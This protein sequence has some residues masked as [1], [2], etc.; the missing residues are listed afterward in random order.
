MSNVNSKISN[1]FIHIHVVDY[2]QRKLMQH[3]HHGYISDMLFAWK[4][5]T[6][7]YILRN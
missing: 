2:I 7:V 4:P 3:Q 5:E 6:K 1:L